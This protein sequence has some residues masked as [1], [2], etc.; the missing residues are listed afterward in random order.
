MLSPVRRGLLL[1]LSLCALC[2]LCGRSAAALDPEL[3]KPYKL[4]VV[5]HVAE[6]RQLTRT[7][8]DLL[9][10]ELR[11]SLQ[12]ALG[13]LASVEVVR[14]HPKLAEVLDKGLS[15][16]DT[17]KDLTDVKTHFVLVDF[18]DGQYEVKAR[19]HDGLTGL[20][21]PVVRT[22]RTPDR[23]FVA[24][25]AALLIGRDFGVVGTVTDRM[26]DDK[27]RVVL[28][29]GGLGVPLERWLRKDEV[30]ALVK[31]RQV[32]GLRAERVEEAV[33][34][35]VEEPKD[36]V[37]V[38]K[39]YSRYRDPLEPGAV[40]YRC[41]HLPTTRTPLRI[42]VVRRNAPMAGEEDP[43]SIQVRRRG[44]TDNVAAAGATDADGVFTTARG[45]ESVLFDHLAFVTVLTPPNDQVNARVPVPLLDDRTV[46]LTVDIKEGDD[47]QLAIRREQWVTQ[48]Y[49]SLFVL[50][51]QFKLLEKLVKDRKGE[52]A[53]E[54]ARAV[55]E[56]VGQDIARLVEGKAKLEED[57]RGVKGAKLDLGEGEQRL[58]E[59][60]AGRK[61]LEEFVARMEQV[62]KDE[63][64]PKRQDLQAKAALGPKL[65]AEG[66]YGKALDLYKE[67][68]DG[69]AA[70]DKLKEHYNRLKDAWEVKG[71]KHAEARKFIYET[72]ATLDPLAV[73]D[74]LDAAR[75]ALEEC[76][77]AGDKLSP[78]RLRV[79]AVAHNG[80]LKEKLAALDPNKDEDRDVIQKIADTSDGLIKL[81][82]DINAF[83]DK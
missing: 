18:V 25:T 83:V 3:A 63:K 56:T 62:I 33:L 80:R 76:K 60:R 30:L 23:L 13:R 47:L 55:H 2:V 31:V 71:E 17:W 15:V 8:K 82:Q 61:K 44:F 27:V 26:D 1:C 70:D 54:K 57:A 22:D 5:L 75:A 6:N 77:K 10:S 41:V 65:E 74:N 32:G 67:V 14:E 78:R 43:R 72:W 37:C 58:D 7:F 69:G 36:G 11:D 34:Q 19:Q 40:G 12:A 4:Q 38:C 28:K 20:A 48:A 50:A 64:D 66:E 52:E 24:R 81:V 39:L 68:I 59:L 9:E 45:K 29:G 35:V 53:I 46:T 21:S 42:R 49:E 51:D 79:L 73:K 16:L